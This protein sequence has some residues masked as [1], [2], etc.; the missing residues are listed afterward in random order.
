MRQTPAGERGSALGVLTAFYDLF[1]GISSFAAGAVA[2]RFGY[3][4]AF[5]TAAGALVAA[6]IAGPFVF[7]TGKRPAPLVF[8]TDF[9]SKSMTAD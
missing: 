2:S 9:Q 6:A 8:E 5:L 1:V 3:S 7:A 4:A